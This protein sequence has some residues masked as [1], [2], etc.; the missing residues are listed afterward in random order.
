MM[1]D[2]IIFIIKVN[3]CLVVLYI[4]Y[5]LLLRKQTFFKLNRIFLIFTLVFALLIPSLRMNIRPA[6]ESSFLSNLS[7]NKVLADNKAFVNNNSQENDINKSTS[8]VQAKKEFQIM[9]ISL[10]NII[11]FIYI[12]GFV[13]FLSRFLLHL[14]KLFSIIRKNGYEK[15]GKIRFVF[16]DKNILPFTFLNYIFLNKN[17]DFFQENEKLIAHEFAHAKQLHSIDL[18]FIELLTVILWFNPVLWLF[19]QSFIELH[20]Y[21]A[22]NNVINN[23]QNLSDY[24]KTLLNQVLKNQKLLSINNFNRS[25]TNKRLSMMTKTKSN[26]KT[27]FRLLLVLPLISVL[28]F[29]FSEPA[30]ITKAKD[31]YADNEI[32]S[33]LIQK[34][35]IQNKKKKIKII[36]NQLILDG[37]VVKLDYLK[38]SVNSKVINTNGVLKPVGIELKL[39]EKIIKFDNGKLKISDTVHLYIPDKLSCKFLKNQL[40]YISAQNLDKDTDID[41]DIETHEI[42]DVDVDVDYEIEVQ[43]E[44]VEK[45]AI[46]ENIV[47]T[48]N[49]VL[50]ENIALSTNIELAENIVQTED[51]VLT[52]NT[53]LAENIA[54]STNIEL[55]ENIVQAEDI[56][57]TGNTVLAENIALSTNIELAENIVQAGNVE[58]LE[59]ETIPEIIETGDYVSIKG[60]VIADKTNKPL[61]GIKVKH[62][63]SGISTR[64]NKKG[65][66][67]ILLKNTKGKLLFEHNKYKSQ[68]AKIGNNDVINARLK[69]INK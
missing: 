26:K 37:K 28:I 64:T 35:N 34:Q 61:Y 13:L 65:E 53:V 54:L 46:A 24:Q 25:L 49:T 55:A 50:A 63:G 51:I 3:I 62:A 43:E 9:Q 19:K 45:I 22:D 29:A 59:V 68:S 17:S 8:T 33:S 48:G 42:E 5:Y 30:E 1:N 57:L 36:N 21:L 47:L 10:T 52:G 15:Y 32:A 66:Y 20:E 16:I 41:T 67:T 18:L 56:V 39:N 69:S 38:I 2:L 44:E 58:L 40:A 4:F 7:I 27:A 60:V 23:E 14:K 12:F 11:I 31:S 6:W